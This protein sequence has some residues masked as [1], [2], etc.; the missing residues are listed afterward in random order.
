[1]GNRT[2]GIIAFSNGVA[3]L[4]TYCESM[5][6]S[7][8]LVMHHGSHELGEISCSKR[9]PIPWFYLQGTAFFTLARWSNVNLCASY[10]YKQ[11]EPPLVFPLNWTSR[12]T[13]LF[14]LFMDKDSQF[15]PQPSTGTSRGG[16]S[17][18]SRSVS[19]PSSSSNAPSSVRRLSLAC[20]YI[21]YR[22]AD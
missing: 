12:I 8:N 18:R 17:S 10:P 6:L 21:L 1:M 16:R 20:V 15:P 22:A 3:I 14:H 5:T 13:L 4:G 11:A 19:T 7:F 2:G 9:L